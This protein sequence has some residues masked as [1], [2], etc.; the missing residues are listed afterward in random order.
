MPCLIWGTAAQAEPVTGDF[1]IL[2]SPR[3]GGRYQANG[4][5]SALLKNVAVEEKL[6]LTTW[7]CDQ[8]RIG[9]ECPRIDEYNLPQLR[10][11]RRLTVSERIDRAVMFIAKELPRLH[12]RFDFGE[13]GPTPERFLAETECWDREDGAGL[14]RIM[15]DAGLML[16]DNDT[17]H[18]YQMRAQGW[19]RYEALTAKATDSKQGFIAMW[20]GKEVDQAYAEGLYKAVEDAGYKPLRI[21]SINH[22]GKV[23]DRIIAEIRRSRFLVADF[24]CEPEKVRGGVYYEAGF[25][26]GLGIEIF[27]TVRESS[28]KDLHFDTRQYNHIVWKDPADL[29][30][31]LKNRIV[32]VLGRG[33]GA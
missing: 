28:V 23:D 5:A 7:L 27:W 25:A 4:T 33:P 21:D 24:S 19:E 12:K 8:R 10:G 26:E 13:H 9:N 18:R 3:A 15:V 2:D 1:T 30:E 32:A 31:K 17:L 11:R 6:V 22:N 20:F 29:R 16:G 14:L